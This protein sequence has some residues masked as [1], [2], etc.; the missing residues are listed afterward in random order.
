MATDGR[1]SEL[2]RRTTS[3][4]SALSYLSAWPDVC[5]GRRRRWTTRAIPDIKTGTTRRST[6]PR[7]RNYFSWS[8]RGR[9]GEFSLGTSRMRN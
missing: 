3:G 2:A 9:R 8:A 4:N 5:H 1:L 6:S 7:N